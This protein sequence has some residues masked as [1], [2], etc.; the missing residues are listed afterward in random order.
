M[1]VN[2]TQSDPLGIL[3]NISL[4]V[5]H[6]YSLAFIRAKQEIAI[7]VTVFIFYP[8]LKLCCHLIREKHIAR[9]LALCVVCW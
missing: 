2:I 4:E 1:R 6:L 7:T 8:P 3:A 9:F 5:A